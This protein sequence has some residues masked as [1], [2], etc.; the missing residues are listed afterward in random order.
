MVTNSTDN[1]NSARESRRN[2]RFEVSQNAFIT[3]A[4]HPEIACEIRDF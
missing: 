4:G 1:P 3:Q 2:K